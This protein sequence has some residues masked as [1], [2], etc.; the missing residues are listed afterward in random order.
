MG[1]GVL[2]AAAVGLSMVVA[3][4]AATLIVAAFL[5]AVAGV[6]GLAGKKKFGKA[7]PPFDRPGEDG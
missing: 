4:C 1:L 5:F 6:A 2:I 3:V 7:G